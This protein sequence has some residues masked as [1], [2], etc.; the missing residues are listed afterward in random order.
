MLMISLKYGFVPGTSWRC[1]NMKNN[2]DAWWGWHLFMWVQSPEHVFQAEI[3][4]AA[5]TMGRSIND[6][7]TILYTAIA[8]KTSMMRNFL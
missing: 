1:E 2:T 5:L 8:L 4:D 7:N 3:E 6:P